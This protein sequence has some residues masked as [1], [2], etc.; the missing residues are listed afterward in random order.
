MTKT[1]VKGSSQATASGSGKVKIKAK[2]FCRRNTTACT[3]TQQLAEQDELH[4]DLNQQIKIL[5]QAQ[6]I[7]DESK[8]VLE[9]T[10]VNVNAIRRLRTQ[11]EELKKM[12]QRVTTWK[13]V[14]SKR[15][16]QRGKYLLHAVEVPMGLAVPEDEKLSLHGRKLVFDGRPV[17]KNHLK[18]PHSLR[19]VA[20]HFLKKKCQSMTLQEV[21][22]LTDRH[23]RRKNDRPYVMTCLLKDF[24]NLLDSKTSM[25][26]QPHYRFFW[27]LRNEP[28]FAK[29]EVVDAASGVSI[30]TTEHKKILHSLNRYNGTLMDHVEFNFLKT[31]ITPSSSPSLLIQQS[32]QQS[33]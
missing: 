20:M 2:F 28:H 5:E 33:V 3:S 24:F 26:A 16:L 21:C 14:C 12:T 15:I 8:K 1:T 18:S 27:C 23:F 10:P 4:Y 30:Y 7:I 9:D 25:E 13:R 19:K 31:L 17:H 29:K 11:Y 6:R 32:I 22:K